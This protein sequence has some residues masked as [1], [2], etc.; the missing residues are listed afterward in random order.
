MKYSYAEMSFLNCSR[1][2]LVLRDKGF[3]RFYSYMPR[4]L[5]YVGSLIL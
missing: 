2:E 4:L 5:D 1:V 3:C